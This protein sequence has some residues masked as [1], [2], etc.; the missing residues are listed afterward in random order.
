MQPDNM[1]NKKNSIGSYLFNSRC[2][3]NASKMVAKFAAL[4]WAEIFRSSLYFELFNNLSHSFNISKD[5]KNTGSN[6]FLP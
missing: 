3:N 2:F 4:A 1:K 5:I 6:Y